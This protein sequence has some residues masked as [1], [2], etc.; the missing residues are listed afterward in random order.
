MIVVEMVERRFLSLGLC[1]GS[2]VHIG[3][4]SKEKTH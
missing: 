3:S 1:I 4:D 2:A